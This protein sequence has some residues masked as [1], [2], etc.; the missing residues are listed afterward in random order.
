MLLSQGRRDQV[1][2]LAAKL[3]REPGG[4]VEAAILR[5]RIHKDHEEFLE[6]RRIL[7][8]LIAR[9]PQAEGPRV[10]LS[11]VLLQ[12]GRDL[13]AAE[14]ILRKIIHLNPLNTEARHNLKVLLA[15]Q[16]RSLEAE[17]AAHRLGQE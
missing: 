4:D 7:E 11:H 6:A 15:K 2:R 16:G 10:L 1:A 3:E 13:T 14:D 12:E 9:L 8:P 5:A 17:V